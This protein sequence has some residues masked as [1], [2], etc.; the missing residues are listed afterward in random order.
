MFDKRTKLSGQVM[1]ELYKYFPDKIFR[2]IV[3]RNVRLSEAPSHGMPISKYDPSSKGAKAY[4]KLAREV[5]EIFL[6]KEI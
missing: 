6:Q 1:E 2:S 5:I 4:S 3:P